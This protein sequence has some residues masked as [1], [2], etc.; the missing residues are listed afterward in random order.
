LGIEQEPDRFLRTRRQHDDA[1]DPAFAAGGFV[2]VGDARRLAPVVGPS[3]VA[4]DWAGYRDCR[5]PAPG[6]V[7]TVAN[8]NCPD[9]AAAVASVAQ[10]QAARAHRFGEHA[11]G[12]R[13][14]GWSLAGIV[15][16]PGAR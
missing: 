3:L 15:S 13:Y 7:H 8:H 2:D 12:F 11:L 4:M 6:E 5:S 9:R 1:A 10:K 14:F 16:R